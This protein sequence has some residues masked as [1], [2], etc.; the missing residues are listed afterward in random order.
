MQL[1][2][3]WLKITIKLHKAIRANDVQM[4]R[5]HIKCTKKRVDYKKRINVMNV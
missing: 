5:K 2:T 1:L 4:V 3:Q